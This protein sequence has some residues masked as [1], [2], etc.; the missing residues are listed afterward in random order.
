MWGSEGNN[1]TCKVVRRAISGKT[2]AEEKRESV[3]HQSACALWLA[4]NRALR[5]R[6]RSVQPLRAQAGKFRTDIL[7]WKGCECARSQLRAE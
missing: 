5:Q 2:T 6:A 3:P 4:R 7:R 1:E